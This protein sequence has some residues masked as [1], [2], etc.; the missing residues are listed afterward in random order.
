MFKHILIATDGSKL[1][2]KAEKA[3]IA[4]ARQSGARVTG[5]CAVREP[6]FRHTRHAELNDEITAE[7]ERRAR[8]SAEKCVAAIGKAAKAAGVIFRPLVTKADVPSRGIIDAA[9]K[10]KCDAI[11]LASHGRGGVSGLIMGSVTHEVLAHSTIPVVV[12]R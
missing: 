10:H 4:F 12:F 11:F 6:H 8:D 9:K 5:Y 1:A 3:G 7:L 2:K